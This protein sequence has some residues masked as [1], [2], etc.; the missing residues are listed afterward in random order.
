MVQTFFCGKI[1]HTSPLQKKERKF[2]LM[3]SAVELFVMYRKDLTRGVAPKQGNHR[4]TEGESRAKE[5]E[6]KRQ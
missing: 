1:G 6:K 5:G 3:S 4:Q 2:I